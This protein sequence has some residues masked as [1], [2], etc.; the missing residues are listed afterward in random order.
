MAENLKYNLK[1]EL[2]KADEE[3]KGSLSLL[4]ISALTF[5]TYNNSMRSVMFTSH[6]RQLVNLLHPDFPGVFTNAEN[7]VGRHSSGYKKAKHDTTVYKKVAKYG[8]LLDKPY[9]YVLFVYDE[10]KK[11]YDVWYRKDAENLTEVFGFEYNNETMDSLEEGDFVPKGSVVQKSTSYDESMNYGY[12]LNVPIMYTLDPSTSEDACIVSQSFADRM[13]SIEISKVSIGINQNDYLLNLYGN[14]KQYK[15][16]PDIGEYSYGE[17]AAKRTLFTN[18][19]LM[20]FKDN[21]LTRIQD[22]DICF[23]KSGQVVDITIYCNNPELED[24]PFNDQILKY[25][26]SQDK[27]WTEIKEICEEIMNSGEKYTHELDYLYKRACAFLN[28]ESKWKDD[29]VFS[30]L[31]IEITVKTVIGL[32]IGQKLSG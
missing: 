11:Q 3:L 4:G 22:S 15:P 5:P 8:D 21:S 25:L 32:Q 9:Y 10:K 16:F 23:Y 6:S 17:V 28:P 14:K 13:T 1:D 30:N 24:V 12:G 29:T 20:D 7:V 18:Q 31:L 2:L 19:L 27:Y 26:A